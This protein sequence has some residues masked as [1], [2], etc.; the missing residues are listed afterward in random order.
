VPVGC[1][2][3]EAALLVSRPPEFMH[4]VEMYWQLKDN[5]MRPGAMSADM[6]HVMSSPEAGAAFVARKQLVPTSCRGFTFNQ[7]PGPLLCTPDTAKRSLSIHNCVLQGE[8]DSW[9]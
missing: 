1:T 4:R 5:T 2:T 3:S 6:T 8:R 9:S 7:L